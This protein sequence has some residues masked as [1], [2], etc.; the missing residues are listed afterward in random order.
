MLRRKKGTKERRKEGEKA[1]VG[2]GIKKDSVQLASAR[3]EVHC[4]KRNMGP[5]SRTGAV[6]I[7]HTGQ[8]T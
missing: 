5:V 8:G 1:K 2:D 7:L 6:A 3:V 4:A